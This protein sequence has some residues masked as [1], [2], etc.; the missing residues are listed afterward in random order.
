MKYISQLIREIIPV[1]IG[2]L[3]ALVINNWNENRKDSIYLNQIY[4]SIEKELKE[5]NSN[6]KETIPKQQV[7]LDNIDMYL[8]DETVSL[9]DIV[10]KTNDG[11]SFAT[12]KNNSWKS[13]ANSKIELISF[14]KLSA[15]TDIDE[16]KESLNLK[17][18]K[19]LDFM[20]NNLKETSQDK[21]EVLK[22][23]IT[24]I[25]WTEENLQSKIEDLIKE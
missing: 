17:N 22:L 6:I 2:I 7:L 4:D 1:I 12:I 10:K 14:E 23:L 13:I 3:I 15:L 21:K 20:Y 11:V 8:K 24:D 25:K 9:I 5:S 16:G 19:I 18:E